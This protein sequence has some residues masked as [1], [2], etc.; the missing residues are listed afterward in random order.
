MDD[1][2]NN[3]VTLL[4]LSLMKRTER[5]SVM[6]H[7][8]HGKERETALTESGKKERK[9]FLSSLSGLLTQIEVRKD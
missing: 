1:R 3:R 7:S 6:G 4:S 9:G 2:A 8:V 5:V